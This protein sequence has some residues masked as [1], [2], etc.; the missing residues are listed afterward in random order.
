MIGLL[1]LTIR[2]LRARKVI[3]GLFAVTTLVWLTLALALQLDVVDGSLAGMSLFGNQADLPT[4][5][6][7]LDDDGDVVLDEAGEV[8]ME[9]REPR[10]GSSLLENF[11]FGAEA[12]AAGAAYWMGI[13]LGLFATGG[14]VAALTER[15]NVDLLLSKPLSRD[16][17][18]AGRLAGVGVV[19]AVLFTY[20]L[21]AIWLVMS[22]KTGV[23]NAHFLLAIGVV[24]LMFAVMYSLVTL[25]SVWSGS[26]PLALVVTLGVLFASL[27]L[28]I[29]DLRLQ[30]MPAWRPLVDVPYYVLPKFG[31]VGAKLVPYLAT[32]GAISPE[33]LAGGA[34]P[35]AAPTVPALAPLLSSVV[36]GLA[37]YAGAFFLFRRTDY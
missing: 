37:C 27:V 35:G 34:Q 8:V 4:E 28:A 12:F 2:E 22:A 6:P 3:V 14:L 19:A 23:W 33:D 29:P 5:Q 7:V 18:L 21:G 11:V 17:V 15:G 24:W 30:L 1:L 26:G 9:P 16:A 36:F 13:V 20:L 25:V 31:S 10:M 32:G